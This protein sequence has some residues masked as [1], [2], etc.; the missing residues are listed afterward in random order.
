MEATQIDG[1]RAETV[2][3]PVHQTVEATF[4][5]RPAVRQPGDRRSADQLDAAQTLIC[6]SLVS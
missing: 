3:L 4:A 5:A 1:D 2:S 6:D